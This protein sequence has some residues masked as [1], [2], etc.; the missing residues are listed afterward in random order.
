MFSWLGRKR[1]KLGT[2]GDKRYNSTKLEIKT[3]FTFLHSRTFV[4]NIYREKKR[5]SEN[6]Y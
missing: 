6:S 5:E 4:A 2:R 3:L 1:R